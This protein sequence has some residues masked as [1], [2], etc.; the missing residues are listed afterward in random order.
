MTVCRRR[1]PAAGAYRHRS[2]RLARRRTCQP[3]VGYL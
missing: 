3:R 1:P 2:G